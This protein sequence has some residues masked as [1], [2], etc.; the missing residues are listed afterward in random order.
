MANQVYDSANEAAA[1]AKKKTAE[2][3]GVAGG[4]DV[5]VV[6]GEFASPGV[7]QDELLQVLDAYAAFRGPDM[8]NCQGLSF[9]AATLLRSGF[10]WK[11]HDFLLKNPDFLLRNLDFLLKNV[12][13]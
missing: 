8:P 13:L 10:Q 4:E 3:G 5:S 12:D 2:G 1:E 7:A 6:G 9:V 11:N